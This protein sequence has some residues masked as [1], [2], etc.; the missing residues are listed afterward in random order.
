MFRTSR[1]NFATSLRGGRGLLR[2]PPFRRLPA[3]RKPSPPTSS[4]TAAR[5]YIDSDAPRADRPQSV[6]L[7]LEHLGRAIYEGIYDPGLKT[8]RRRRLSKRCDGRSKASRRA[9][10]SL[11]GGNFVSGY[12]WLD[13]VGPKKDRPMVLDKGLELADS[14]QFGTNEFSPGARRPA[15]N[16]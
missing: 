4:G 9:H 8:L 6:R 10:H 11:P 1:R 3:G 13:G 2:R 14:N 16:R 5:V 7:F 12:N 15:P